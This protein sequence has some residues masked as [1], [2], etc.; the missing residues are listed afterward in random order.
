MSK[1]IKQPKLRSTKNDCIYT[2]KPLADLA[3]SYCNILPTDIVLDPC[4]GGGV[5][6]DN[7]PDCDKRWCEIEKDKDFFEFTEKV[8]WVVGNPPFSIWNKWLKHTVEICDK[9]CYII[10]SLN[11]IPNRL[12]LIQ[13]AGFG[14]TVYH[15]V[16]VYWWFSP[17]VILVAERGKTS[18][19]NFTSEVFL[20]DIC[21]K[22]CLRGRGGVGFNECKEKI[23]KYN[24]NV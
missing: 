3:I 19:I 22:R 7:L 5:F 20:C 13:D 6:F 4:S 1:N 21:N 10:G 18:I 17:V 9:F 15:L 11:V 2:P 14:I 16:K 8:D 23:Y 12:K 24:K